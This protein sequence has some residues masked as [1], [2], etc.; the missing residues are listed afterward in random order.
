M[1]LRNNPG[2]I[3]AT[4]MAKEAFPFHGNQGNRNL[5]FRFAAAVPREVIKFVPSKN[6]SR[7][8]DSGPEFEIIYRKS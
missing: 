4:L 2:L 7:S 5:Q 8:A 1:R 3:L 6:L